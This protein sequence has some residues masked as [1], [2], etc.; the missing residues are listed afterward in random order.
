MLCNCKNPVMQIIDVVHAKWKANSFQIAPRDYG[1]LTFRVKGTAKIKVDDQTYFVKENEVLYLPQGVAYT[2]EYDDNEILAIHFKTRDSD[3]APE[4]YPLA[5]SEEI[6]RAFLRADAYWTEK[7]PGFEAN[8][9]AQLYAILGKLCS[10]AVTRRLPEHFLRAISYINA[11]Y[12]SAAL[13]IQTVCQAAGISAT[14]LRTLFQKYYQKTPT[15]YIT[16]LRLEYARALISC[17]ASIEEA[18]EQSGF[19]D[20]KYFSRVV[21]KHLLCTPRELKSYGK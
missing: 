21:K 19:N 12:K 11:N 2:A 16:Q 18:A 7:A 20:P 9:L 6:H 1:A 4:V 10:N 17:G 15:D 14:T 13:S 8:V 5:D 3:K